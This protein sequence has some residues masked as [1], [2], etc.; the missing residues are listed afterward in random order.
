ME[1]ETPALSAVAASDPYLDSFQTSY[2][3]PLAPRGLPLYLQTSPE[4]HMKR[5]LAAGSGP[6]YQ[7]CKAFRNAE[8][9]SRHNPEFTMLEWYRPGFDHL[10]LMD[11]V[12]ELVKLI[13]GA[14]HVRR[15][16]YQQLFVDVLGLDPFNCSVEDL[17][18][19][20][21]QH[22]IQISD[23]PDASLD[24]WLSLVM[25]HLIEP[26]MGAEPLMVYDFPASQAM[27]ARVRDGEPPAAERFELY[28]NGIE[29]A[30]GFHELS[31]A[32]E[33]QARFEDNIEKRRASGLPA[34]EI[35]SALLDALRSGLP[36]A[37]GVALGVDR[38]VMLA[39]GVNSLAEVMAFPL[40][41][42]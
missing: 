4:Y 14:E 2:Q 29:L 21:D 30:N 31:D 17:Q 8:A 20:L 16:S 32:N 28:V 37:A 26:A 34:L 35:D 24:D 39:A 13:L 33:Q 3:G 9:G 18:D 23:M 42:A 41:R 15:M 38:L 10:A 19:C 36:H 25:S 7:L 6:I 27:L 12:A 11:E 1:V 5:L 40:E 22:G